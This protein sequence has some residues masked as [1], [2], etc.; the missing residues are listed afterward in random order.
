MLAYLGF[1]EKNPNGI[2]KEIAK[3]VNEKTYNVL[4]ICQVF[5]SAYFVIFICPKFIILKFEYLSLE[6]TVQHF[7]AYAMKH[8]MRLENFAAE[9]YVFLCEMQQ[10]Q[11]EKCC[12]QHHHVACN[13]SVA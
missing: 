12:M 6:T 8:C 3:K 4:G 1:L 2:K 10:E 7:H 9:P 5:V 11:F 13:I